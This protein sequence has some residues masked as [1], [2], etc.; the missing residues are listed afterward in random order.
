MSTENISITVDADAARSFCE[1][2]PKDRRKLE[3]LLGLRLRE[4]TSK[5]ARPLT[6]IMQEIGT[7]AEA[8]GLTPEMLETM[9]R[10]E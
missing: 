7:Q 8:K 1:A 4:L 3:L 5:D 10:E 6:E 9:L 2:S